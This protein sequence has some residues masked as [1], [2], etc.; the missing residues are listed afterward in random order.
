MSGLSFFDALGVRGVDRKPLIITELA[1]EPLQSPARFMQNSL[2]IA[3][4]L[5]QT[6][7]CYNFN[8]YLGNKYHG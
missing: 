7:I 6:T 3:L 5:Y 1:E 8:S 4:K 2:E